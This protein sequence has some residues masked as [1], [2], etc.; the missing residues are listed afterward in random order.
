LSLPLLEERPD[1]LAQRLGERHLALGWTRAQRRARH[2]QP[3]HHDVPPVD[4]HA[5]AAQER[6]HHEP[7]F[8][9]QAFQVLLD[10]VA[11][12]HVEDDVDAALAGDPRNLRDEIV[13]VVVD[14]MI[15]AERPAK[16]GLVVAPCRGE[17]RGAEL[18]GKLNGAKADAARAA[19]DQHFLALL[20]AP[21][22]DEVVPDGEVIFRQARGFE[23]REALG[24]RQA[25][26]RGRRAVFGVPA[27]GRQ[28]ADGFADSDDA[29]PGPQATIVPAISS[30]MIG[31][32]SGGGG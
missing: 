31:D 17:H 9:R 22:I 7:A 16:R 15:G 6:D 5:P 10:V 19:V 24:N 14:R 26:A 2:G 4:L 32:A 20:Q 1:V 27:P 30:P 3:T 28:R 21:A 23:R 8:K 13:R 29:T 12:D 18:L 25:E 11:A